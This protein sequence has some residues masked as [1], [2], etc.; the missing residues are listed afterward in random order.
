MQTC[1]S[2]ICQQHSPLTVAGAVADL[3]AIWQHLTAFP[4]I[5]TANRTDQSYPIRNPYYD[6]MK[7]GFALQCSRFAQ[8]QG[9]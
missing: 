5:R 1:I 2:G 4:I 8:A 9:F 3:S 7:G 6:S